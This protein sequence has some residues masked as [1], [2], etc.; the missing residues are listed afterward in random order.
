VQTQRERL[1]HKLGDPREIR[2]ERD[3]LQSALTQFAREHTEIFDEFAERKVHLPGLWAN[4]AFGER[5]ENPRL[6][7]E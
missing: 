4:R 3:A 7:N 1:A 6:L 5:P 2:S